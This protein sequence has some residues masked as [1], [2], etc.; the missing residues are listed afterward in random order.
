MTTDRPYHR[1]LT[2][3]EAFAEVTAGRGEQ[4]APAVVEAFHRTA[5][6][7]PF[8]LGLEPPPGEALQA[9]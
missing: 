8:E 3:A 1:A 6:R 4:F 5:E 7:R 9:G 2:I